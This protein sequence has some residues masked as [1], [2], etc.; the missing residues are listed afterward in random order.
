M[1]AVFWYKAECSVQ[2]TD[3]LFGGKYWV[4]DQAVPVSDWSVAFYQ[5][6]RHHKQEECSH[7]SYS[8]GNHNFCIVA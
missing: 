6:Q 7:R 4:Y 2:E 3:R 5:I 8:I 1:I